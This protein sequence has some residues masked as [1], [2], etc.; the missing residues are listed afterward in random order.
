M[1][2]AAFAALPSDDTFAIGPGAVLT[3]RGSIVAQPA[4]GHAAGQQ[5][6]RLPYMLVPRGLS[7]VTTGTPSTW[8]HTTGGTF[9]SSLPISNSG[10]HSGTAD[11]YTWGITD[12]RESGQPMDVRDV[13]V[14]ILPGAAL[15]GADS[16]RSL[17][18]LINTWGQSTNQ[19]VNEYDINVDVNG[20]GKADFIVVG[21]DLGFVFT[22]SY[23]GIPASFTVNAKTGAIVDAF[24][25]DAPMNGSTVELPVLA[26]DLGRFKKG[27]AQRFA[28]SVNAFSL[29]PGAL[30][31]TTGSALINPFSPTVSSGDFATLAAG[32][33]TSFALTFNKNQQAR[34]PVLGWLVA[35]VDDANGAPQAAE[36]AAPAG[37]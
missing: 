26:S 27:S 33:S 11:L 34:T 7:N 31:D 22:G 19:S 21:I 3:V 37:L 16:D 4:S 9:T 13:G 24:L 25:A 30:V 28:Y 5:P 15:G 12:P 1:S 8:T 18:F 20:D 32:T 17:I 10:I 36:V 35:S 23:N 2:A 29:V 6:I 14:Q